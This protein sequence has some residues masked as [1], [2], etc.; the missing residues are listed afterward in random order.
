MPGATLSPQ[1]KRTANGRRTFLEKFSTPDEKSQY[2][3]ALGR[4]AAEN[5]FVLTGDEAS[6]L[7]EAYAILSRIAARVSPR[8]PGH[9]K[10]AEDSSPAA[11]GGER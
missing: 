2:F 11:G 4:R 6:A 1:Q 5:R 10:A 3:Q 8:P 7:A 9:E